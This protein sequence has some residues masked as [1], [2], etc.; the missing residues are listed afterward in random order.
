[1]YEMNTKDTLLVFT[2]GGNYI[3]LPVFELTENKW[4]DEGVHI[5]NVVTLTSEEYIIGALLVKDFK[6]ANHI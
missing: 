6:E 4:K 1:M 2:S 5:N 3:Y